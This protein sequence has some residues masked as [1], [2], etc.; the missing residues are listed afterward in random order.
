MNVMSKAHTASSRAGG[1]TADHYVRRHILHGASVADA[2]WVDEIFQLETA[3]WAQLQKLKDRQW[4]LS[5]DEN[6]FGALF[7]QWKGTPVVDRLLR[8]RLL[9]LLA[10]GNRVVLRECRR[11]ERQ[12]FDW[13]SSLI[14]DGARFETPLA[15]VLRQARATFKFDNPARYNLCLSH[16]RRVR[17]NAELN[18]H[19][20]PQEG[21]R[22]IKAT[23]QRGQLCAA[24]NML[25]WPGLELL[26]CS[27]SGRRIKNNVTYKVQ[28]LNDE[29]LVIESETE[30]MTLSYA[31]AA[32]LLR[33]S[34]AR[35]YASIQGTDFDDTVRLHDTTSKHFT[36][37]HLF[38]AMSRCRFADNLAI[39]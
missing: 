29:H 4:L 16:R 8:S 26:G 10:G 3:L 15:D 12:L 17:L 28:I 14:P 33:L 34:F 35:T 38:V 6:Q 21:W 9:Y 11:S 2:L 23:A 24:Q 5:G 20:C 7:D 36:R 30:N 19:F 31:Q 39:E 1:G 18:K 25:V 37:R 22:L 32:E 27:R 13:Y